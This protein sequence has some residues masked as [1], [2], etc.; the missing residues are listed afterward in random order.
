MSF[1]KF[2][3]PPSCPTRHEKILDL[4]LNAYDMNLMKSYMYSLQVLTEEVTFA[5]CVY[6][7]V[8]V[9]VCVCMCVCVCVSCC[10]LMS[11]LLRPSNISATSHNS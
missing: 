1:L 7:C 8:C 2:T 4:L 3:D 11:I 6:V 5:V 9:C 10:Y